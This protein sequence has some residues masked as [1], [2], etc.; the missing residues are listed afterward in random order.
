MTSPPEKPNLHMP[1]A[2]RQGISTA[3]ATRPGNAF[4]PILVE[5]HR[6]EVG[7]FRP[8][9]DGV[10]SLLD[11]SDPG[12]SAHAQ[13]SVGKPQPKFTQPMRDDFG[14]QGFLPVLRARV[15]VEVPDT[16][17]RTGNRIFEKRAER[18]VQIGMC[19][20]QKR[21]VEADLYLGA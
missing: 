11:W 9:M 3:Y 13:R 21:S 15:D 1:G 5:I 16:M 10:Q 17:P 7:L 12:A 18:E 2:R 20:G 4:G 6:S 14:G 19:L 8:T